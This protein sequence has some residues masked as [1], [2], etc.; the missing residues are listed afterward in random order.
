[1]QN[2]MWILM[3]E[4]VHFYLDSSPGPATSSTNEAYDINAALGLAATDAISNAQSYVWYSACKSLAFSV[5]VS[6]T[7]DFWRLL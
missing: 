3:H 7:S 1:M 4:I 2:Q 6:W 5:G